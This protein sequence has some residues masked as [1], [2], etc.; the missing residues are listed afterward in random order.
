MALKAYERCYVC[1]L[2]CPRKGMSISHLDSDAELIFLNAM[3]KKYD[4]MYVAKYFLW[5]LCLTPRQNV[6]K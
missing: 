2:T 1:V 4:L 6:A 3:E 5:G